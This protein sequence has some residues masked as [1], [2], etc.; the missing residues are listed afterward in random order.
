MAG[1][2]LLSW[3]SSQ[4]VTIHPSSVHTPTAIHPSSVHTPTAIHPSSVRTYPLLSIHHLST[5]THCHC[6]L[7]AAAV[8]AGGNV[9]K[10]T[11]A[12]PSEGLLPP[13]VPDPCLIDLQAK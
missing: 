12:G 9:P 1:S 7:P 11:V 5:H 10:S 13:A 6:T 4:S 3:P 8:R 2:P